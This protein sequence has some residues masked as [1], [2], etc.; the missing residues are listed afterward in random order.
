MISCAAAVGEMLSGGTLK[1]SELF[2]L[3]GTIP[4]KL[5]EYL[6]VGWKGGFVPK[7]QREIAF[8]AI[9]RTGKPWA[10]EL[11]DQFYHRVEMG[12]MVVVDGFDAAGNIKIRD[13]MHATRYEMTRE[14]FF[15]HWSDRAIFNPL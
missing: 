10:A 12:H 2:E 6:G 7:L 11:R 14:D 8:D 13:P 15:E 5:A 3:V 9:M 1:Q 4:E